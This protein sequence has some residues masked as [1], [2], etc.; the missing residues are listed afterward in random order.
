MLLYDLGTIPWKQ[1][2]L[3]YHALARCDKQALVICTPEKEYACVGFHQDP[4]FELDLEYCVNRKIGIFRREIGGGTVLLDKNQLFYQII[5][6]R[7]K[8][9][10]DQRVLFRKLLEPVI[11]TYK[12]LG[13]DAKYNPVSD[14]VVNG[15]KISGNG[16]GDIGNCKVMTGSILLD[17]DC[18]TM[19]RILRLSSERFRKDVYLAMKDNLTN[20]KRELG[21]IP[22]YKELKSILISNYEDVFGSLEKSDLSSEVVNKMQE[23]DKKFSTNDWLFKNMKKPGHRTIKIIEGM[24]LSH[25]VHKGVEMCIGSKNQ[26]IRHIKIYSQ[27]SQENSSRLNELLVGNKLDES[28]IYNSIDL[29]L[30]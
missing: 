15:K 9:S 22:E 20:V 6:D 26:E 10:L 21:Y 29:V 28:T 18:E 7:E 12:A 24:T 25:I 1:T 13:I 14:L 3:V 19:G 27:I 30:S 4:A 16:G 11:R 2:Q 17:F 8:A 23:L 5:I